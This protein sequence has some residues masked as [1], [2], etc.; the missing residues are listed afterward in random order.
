MAFPMT[1]KDSVWLL[2]PVAMMYDEICR[3]LNSTE[4]ASP[5]L[6]E[7]EKMAMNPKSDC[8]YPPTS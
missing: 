4:Y 2:V 6:A 7:A 1:T 5:S 3:P 8:S